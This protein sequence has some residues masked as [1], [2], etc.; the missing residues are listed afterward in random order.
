MRERGREKVMRERERKKDAR[1]NEKV[2]VSE[3]GMTDR[4]TSDSHSK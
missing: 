3:E 4:G 1:S 2:K